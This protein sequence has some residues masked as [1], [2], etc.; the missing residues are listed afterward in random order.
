[1][2]YTLLLSI[3]IDRM[4]NS[5]LKIPNLI[6]LGVN[7]NSSQNGSINPM[8]FNALR[9]NAMPFN[10]MNGL[11]NFNMGINMGINM[12]MNMSI[13]MNMNQSMPMMIASQVPLP[14]PP[15]SCKP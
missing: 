9:M 13:G 2:D 3:R 11:P 12:N 14:P 15:P 10:P 8:D 7:V 5:N 1:M 4:S 6:D